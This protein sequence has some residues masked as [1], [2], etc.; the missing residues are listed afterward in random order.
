MEYKRLTKKG[1]LNFAD[2]DL[3]LADEWG[4]SHIYNRLAEFEDKIEQGKLKEINYPWQVGDKV[5]VVRSATSNNKNFYI[6]EDTVVQTCVYKNV[7]ANTF[8][9][10]IKLMENMSVL[11]WDFDKVFLTREEAE[12]R[13]KELQNVQAKAN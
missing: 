6:F 1:G 5:F 13:L 2:K 11:E 9:L 7:E 3:S 12:K 10:F 4:Y 8:W